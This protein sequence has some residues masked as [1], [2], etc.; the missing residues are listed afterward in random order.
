M[1]EEETAFKTASKEFA[2]PK[3]TFWEI[4]MELAIFG[5]MIFVIFFVIRPYVAE[6]YLVDG[7]SMDPTFATSDYLIVNKISYELGS[8][9]RNTVVVFRYPNDPTKSFIKRIIGLPGETVKMKDN[10]VTII[11]QENPN[12]L[13]IDQSYVVHKC[14]DTSKCVNTFE[15]TLTNEEYFVMGDNRA[16]SFDSRSWGPLNKKYI[17]GEPFVRLWPINSIGYLPGSDSK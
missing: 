15:K 3:T 16:E 11:N 5:V 17:S 2:Q 9:D 14:T 7:R 4:V 1:N 10:V 13:N 8:P 6:P 12:G